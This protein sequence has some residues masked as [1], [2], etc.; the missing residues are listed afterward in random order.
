MKKDFNVVSKE[1]HLW[2][3][4]ISQF[5]NLRFY[6]LYGMGFIFFLALTVKFPVWGGL[7]MLLFLTL[8]LE[9]Y[10]TVR[11]TKFDLT[12][13]RM[14]I[15]KGGLFGGRRTFEINISDLTDAELHESFIHQMVGIGNIKL[16]FLGN[17]L[18]TTYRDLYEINYHIIPG[19]K[20]PARSR[21]I[22]RAAIKRSNNLIDPQEYTFNFNEQKRNQKILGRKK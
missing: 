3:S 8:A 10:I 4:D 5:V 18:L 2:G 13:E 20:D 19:V 1:A 22:I 12:H 21:E 17:A 15:V 7:G 9:K 6:I 14:R 16:H 11:D